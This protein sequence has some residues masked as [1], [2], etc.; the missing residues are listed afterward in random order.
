M[1]PIGHANDGG[2]S[3]RIPAACCGLVGLKP[4]RGRISAGPRLGQSF[5]STD[6]VLTRTV[7]DTAALLD[8][9]AGYELGDA[10]WAPPPREDFVEAASPAGAAA[11]QVAGGLRIALVQ[12][13]PLDDAAIDPLCAKAA[14][15]AAALLESLGHRVEELA[16]PWSGVNLDE[17]FTRAF[18]PGAGQ[19]V[20]AGAD[21]AG[22]EPRPEDVEPL[23]WALYERALN[24]GTL[25][26][27]DARDRLEAFGRK[28]VSGFAGH[29]VVLTPALG[30]RP[31]PT[32]TISG[33]S[34]DPWAT[35]HRSGLFT[36]F[37]AVINITGLP[38]ISLPL[39]HGGDGLPLGVQLIGPP[40]GEELLLAL[41][42]Q[43]EAALPW[44][45]R[46]PSL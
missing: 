31:V 9:L 41:S 7:A 5:L 4:A 27:L 36:P 34:P 22:R 43:L 20:V 23:T 3:T 21:M 11:K 15:D 37:T 12:D 2:G 26:Y 29:D 35:Y 46:R 24:Q 19:L 40:A 10:N 44:A 38:A 39:F 45:A 14:S 6:G 16:A 42:T 13:P 8:V 17:D 33:L 25:E 32:G 30:Q 1:V 28:V 18:G